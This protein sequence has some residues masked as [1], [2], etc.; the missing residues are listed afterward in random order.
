[1]YCKISNSHPLA[2]QDELFWH[3]IVWVPEENNCYYYQ[4]SKPNQF[5]DIPSDA[6]QIRDNRDIDLRDLNVQS[7]WGKMVSRLVM[8]G[9]AVLTD[10]DRGYGL[11][12]RTPSFGG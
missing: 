6:K 7:L 8:G 1:M 2:P 5:D 12:T 3:H 9:Y 10:T 11:V 4:C